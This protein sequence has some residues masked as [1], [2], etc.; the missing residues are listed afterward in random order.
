MV[1]PYDSIDRLEGQ[2]KR[3]RERERTSSY[4]SPQEIAEERDRRVKINVL[5][6][7]RDD[8]PTGDEDNWGDI[9]PPLLD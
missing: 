9:F 7:T 3:F 2:S 8:G 5:W 6:N 4:V 1:Y